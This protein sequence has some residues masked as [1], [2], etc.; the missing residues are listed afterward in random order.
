[1]TTKTID[2]ARFHKLYGPKQPRVNYYAKDFLDYVIMIV[3]TVALV[4]LAYGPRHVISVAGFALCAFLLVAFVVRHGVELRVPA[5]LRR[6]Q[7]ILYSIVYKLRNV[8]LILVIGL[9]VL[10]AEN[11]LIAA[12]PGLPHKVEWTRTA[13]LWLFYAHLI[14]ITVYRTAILVEHLNKRELV[15][16][17]LMQTPWKRVIKEKTNIVLEIVHAYATGV[18]THIVLIAP[19]YLVVTHLRFSLLFLP[20]S[21]ALSVLVHRQWLKTYNTW[22]Y[23]D[24]WLGH[25]SE[26]EFLF[27]HGTHHDAIPSGLIAVADNGLLEGFTR[28][29]MGSPVALYNPILAFLVFTTDVKADIDLHQYIPGVRPTISKRLMGIYQHSTHHYGRLE[30]YSM[31]MSVEQDTSVNWK[32]M[33]V[34]LPDEVLNSFKLDEML[35]GTEW[36]NPTHLSTLRLYEKYLPAQPATAPAATV[37]PE[38]PAP[39]A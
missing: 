11:V 12:T 26:V 16:E 33:F 17:V 37:Q 1:M 32:R 2:P 19:W 3:M 23:R 36:N 29:T 15:R 31:A 25:N 34:W 35:T 6:P 18:L 8:P 5:L 20:V 9:G 7:E 21:I 4:A 38:Q 10:L 30:P 22:Y 39:T 14:V 13:A 28:Y 27:L 24:H